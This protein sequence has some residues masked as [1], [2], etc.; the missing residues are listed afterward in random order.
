MKYFDLSELQYYIYKIFFII[1]TVT[2][3]D[4]CRIATLLA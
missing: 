2:G 3:Y 1:V 4:C